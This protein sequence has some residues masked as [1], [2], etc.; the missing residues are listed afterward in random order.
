MSWELT[1]NNGTNPNA[2]FLGTTDNQPLIIKTNSNSPDSPEAMRISANG[3]VTIGTVIETDLSTKL[4]VSE[5]HIGVLGVSDTFDQTLYLYNNVGKELRLTVGA[6]S[7]GT[8]WY[9]QANTGTLG[10]GSGMDL[11]FSAGAAEAM[12]IV[13]NAV[14][15][16]LKIP[17]L[18]RVGD[19]NANA[20]AQ[21]VKTLLGDFGE[22]IGRFFSG[23]RHSSFS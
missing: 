20:L 12:R 15:R 10:V 23:R 13:A 6:N 5:G 16:C 22:T 17:R 2:N 9:T 11:R 21:V 18:H 7:G 4:Q 1:G 8:A 19:R 3:H 14:A